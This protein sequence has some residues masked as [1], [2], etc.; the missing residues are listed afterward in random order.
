MI[1]LHWLI[2]VCKA[3]GCTWGGAWQEVKE[4]RL[5]ELEAPGEEWDLVMQAWE[6]DVV[7]ADAALSYLV[8]GGEP[9]GKEKRGRG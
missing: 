1:L 2:N 3:Q 7:A 8:G 5:G 9:A 6:Q 4:A